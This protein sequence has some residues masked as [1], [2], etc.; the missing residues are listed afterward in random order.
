V[1][2]EYDRFA[3]QA[4]PTLSVEE[5]ARITALAADIPALW[6]SPHT[7]NADRQAIIRCLVERVVVRGEANSER[8]TATIRWAGGSESQQEF[9]RPVRTD[10]QLAQGE[11]LM[12][13]LAEWRDAGKTAAQTATILNAEDFSPTNPRDIFNG[14]IV[15]SLLLKLGLRGE[16]HDD[17]LLEKG[18]WWIRDLADRIDVPWQTL[19]EWAIKGWAHGRQ[20]KVQKLWIIWADR[21]EV[22]RFRR[23]RS[24][25]HRGTLGYPPDLTTPKQRS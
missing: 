16:Q 14:N 1:Q 9:A 25:Q 2:E 18:E 12:Q 17:S 4:L 5:S 19:R 24:A 22:K 13:R 10:Q 15:R 8:V 21:D 11:A 7:T 3:Q 23:L 6:Q 20:T